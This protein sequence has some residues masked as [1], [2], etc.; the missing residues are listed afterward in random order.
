MAIGGLYTIPAGVGFADALAAGL[1]QEAEQN[2]LALARMTV[3]LPTRRAVRALREAFLRLGGGQPML[4]PALRPVGDID[5]DAADLAALDVAAGGADLPPAIPGLRR[6]LLL[7]RLVQKFLSLDAAADAAARIDHAVLLA[8]ELARLVDQAHTEGVGFERLTGLAPERYAAHWQDVLRFLAVATEHWP[9]VLAAEGATEAP[10]RHA[11]LVDRLIALWRRNPPADPVVVAG[12]TGSIPATARLMR[13]VLDLPAGAIVLPGL[14]TEADEATWAAV[15]DDPGHAQHGLAQLLDRLDSTRRDV[16]PWPAAGDPAPSARARL[17]AEALRPAATTEAWRRLPETAPDLLR[18]A[19]AGLDMI[20]APTQQEEAGI[21]ALLLREALQ[22]PNST[23][24]LVTPDR[25]LAR[26]VKTALGRW[27]IEVDDSAG[28]PLAETPAMAFWLLTADL[29][30]KEAA[31]VPL[32]AALKHPLAAAGLAP[33]AFRARIR[34]FERAA[35][36]GPRPAPGVLGLKSVAGAIEDP[37]IRAEASAWIDRLAEPLDRLTGLLSARQATLT[38]L[39]S[40]HNAFA[41]RLAASDRETGTERLWAGEAGEEAAAFLGDLVEAARDFPPIPGRAY[42]PL[43]E[44]LVAGRVH[45][46]RYGAHPRL[47]ILGPL[48]ARLQRYDLMVLGGLVEGVWPPDPGADPWMSRPMRQAFG[49]PSPERRI[50]LSAHDFQIA[51]NAPRVVMTRSD[52]IDGAPAVPSRWWLRLE[53]VLDALGLADTV[54]TRAIGLRGWAEALDA[55]RAGRPGLVAPPAPKPP[56]AS[57]PRNFSVTEIETWVRDPYAIYAKKILDL[58]ALDPLDAD[59]GAADRGTL[60]H[61][62]LDRF[63]REFPRELPPDAL[64]RLLAVG[65]EVFAPKMAQPAVHAFWWPRFVRVAEWFLGQEKERRVAIAEVLTER[66]GKVTLAEPARPVTLRGKADRI[67]RRRD[68]G[69]V[70][71]DYKTGAPPSG[72]QVAAGYAPQL[73]LEAMML[74]AGGFADIGAG[75]CAGLEYWRLSGGAEAG[76]VKPLKGDAATLAAEARERLLA[77]VAEFDK[78]ETPYLSVPDRT[79]APRYSDYDHL[80]RIK[81]WSAG[82]GED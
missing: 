40:T 22:D 1:W 18:G 27:G 45:R 60:I 15:G 70:I 38:D 77:L 30:G 57:R 41:E 16:R 76:E 19:T 5:E 48:E 75:A 2:P 7:A 53:T 35:L 81:E 59:P 31:P 36:R 62:A 68:G 82:V 64:D 33:A 66:W 47:A 23:A 56:L 12:S 32:L 28:R 61:E 71:V 74:E 49:L 79:R 46:P 10:L 63:V 67:E 51:A 72:P 13:A 54:K 42:L 73:P 39:L 8:G 44:A 17:I 34:A 80:A 50:G 14:D 3:L 65:R 11:A 52:R 29:A 69:Y 43:L 21:V 25:R 37:A 78:E 4:L 6:Q 26:R 58:R 24:A 9:E 20:A 55:P